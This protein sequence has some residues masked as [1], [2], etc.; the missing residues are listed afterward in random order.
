MFSYSW[1][2][3]M[4]CTLKKLNHI[5]PSMVSVALRSLCD[6]CQLAPVRKIKQIEEFCLSGQR[7][8][9]VLLS[10]CLSV[11]FA[12]QRTAD[13]SVK[14]HFITQQRNASNKTWHSVIFIK[15]E[16]FEK[17]L[18]FKKKWNVLLRTDDWCFLI[19]MVSSGAAREPKV[20]MC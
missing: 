11:W 5:L 4:L 7:L 10:F 3:L 18:C 14:T 19:V 1:T 6:S 15:N 2:H 8:A 17:M 20:I 12:V 13:E 9:G 16:M